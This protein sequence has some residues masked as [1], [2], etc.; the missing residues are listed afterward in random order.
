MK[1]QRQSAKTIH[2]I[3]LEAGVSATTVSFVL[4]NKGNINWKTRARVLDIVERSNYVPNE[5]ARRL[6]TQ[7]SG[8]L[9]V[10]IDH[11]HNGFFNAVFDGIGSVA[12]R[13]GYSFL[14]AES[15]EDPEKEKREVLLLLQHG[16]DGLILFPCSSN[17]SHLS[18][19]QERYQVP[20][21][22]IGNAYS[23]NLFPSVVADN[24]QGAR[25][26]TQ[27][28]ISL[29]R[30]PILHIA[31][32]DSQSMCRHRRKGFMAVM[33]EEADVNDTESLVFEALDLSIREGYHAME[34]INKRFRP[35]FSVFVV[36][37]DTA[38]G[39][40]KYCNRRDFRI[41]EDVS[42]IGFS[43]IDLID[44]LDLGLS[45]IHIP[46]MEMG[47]KAAE[48]LVTCAQRGDSTCRPEQVTLPVKLIDRRSTSDVL[49]ESPS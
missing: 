28:L 18:E 45:S 21:V 19:T 32:P 1:K 44:E 36:N 11:F 35:P 37:D 9:G 20:V 43:N 24:E 7:K 47:R 33:Q 15:Q 38:M 29:G 5:A 30:E 8:S 10:I 4:N 27:K 39:V 14:V 41:P 12:D 42:L 48:L 40:I 3:A 22:L 2:D 6:R 26:A 16:V 46:A 17:S 25:L 34:R 23:K 13:N 49:F 31:G